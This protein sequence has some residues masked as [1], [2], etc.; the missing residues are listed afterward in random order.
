M[1]PPEAGPAGP[2]RALADA[3]PPPIV[4]RM[5]ELLLF[6]AGALLVLAGLAYALRRYV[7]FRR[8]DCCG[9]GCGC[10]FPKA[11]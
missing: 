11:R 4:P 6:A 1:I 9:K 10:L 2:A 5:P 3:A 8:R 7:C